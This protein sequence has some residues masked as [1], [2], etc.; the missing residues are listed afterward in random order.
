MSEGSCCPTGSLP[1]LIPP[2]NYHE[3]G[4]V[5]Q[6]NDDLMVYVVGSGP[7]G[8]IVNY[9]IYGFNSGRTRAICDEIASFGYTVVLPDY[10][11]GDCWTAEREMHETMEVKQN[12]IRLHSNPNSIM[13]DIEH[14]ILPFFK[15]RN[16]AKIGCLGFC[17]GGYVSFL[18]SQTN[19]VLCG[20]GCHTS[21][22]IFNMYE[23]NEIEA[24]EKILCPQMI[25]QASNDLPNTK[26][27]GEVH[28]AL[29]RLPFG[30]HCVVQEFEE[31][32]HGW[33]PRGNLNDPVVARN[34]A[35]AMKLVIDFLQKFL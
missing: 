33:V 6:F 10:F 20:I 23:T 5:I 11:R 27:G 24:A 17:F 35:V 25:L 18:L 30:N 14:S 2:E 32:L 34:V 7:C 26:P 8:V 19:Q 9:D 4:T 16:I 28:L 22:K 29:S 12:F 1:S 13:S 21:I 31:V 15:E 3:Q